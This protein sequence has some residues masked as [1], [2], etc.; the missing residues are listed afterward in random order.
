MAAWT[1]TSPATGCD[2][3]VLGVAPGGSGI[4]TQSGGTNMSIGHF[5]EQGFRE[6]TSRLLAAAWLQPRRLRSVQPERRLVER[7]RRLRGR[8]TP[9]KCDTAVK[10]ARECS[11]KRAEPSGTFGTPGRERTRPIGLVVGGNWTNNG[12]GLP[13]SPVTQPCVG[14][15]SLGNTNG[16]ARRSSSAA[17]KSSALAARA[18]S[19][20]TAEPTPSSA[21]VTTDR[22]PCGPIR[23]PL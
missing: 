16:P 9:I 14:T 18:R 7:G 19:R 23:Q 15:Y 12:I 17:P 1:A 21:A 11:S 6:M 3:E 20:R 13:N 22:L 2:Q 8:Q 5:P 4:F 10:P